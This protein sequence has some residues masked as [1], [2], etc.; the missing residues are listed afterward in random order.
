M[1][2]RIFIQAILLAI[3]THFEICKAV[4]LIKSQQHLSANDDEYV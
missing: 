2:F 3:V 1:S 4:N